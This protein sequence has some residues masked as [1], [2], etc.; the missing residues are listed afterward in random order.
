MKKRFL[1]I[2]GLCLLVFAVF[3]L[4]S[5]NNQSDKEWNMIVDSGDETDVVMA[6][7]TSNEAFL[8]YLEGD[9]SDYMREK[10]Q[11]R[12]VVKKVLIEQVVSKLDEEKAL[13]EEGQDV[14]GSYDVLLFDG[15]GY[16]EMR[17]K[18]LI[19]GPFSNNLE[20]LGLI[21]LY[22]SSFQYRD[23]VPNEGFFVPIARKMLTLLYSEDIFYESPVSYAELISEL[24]KLQ[25]M[26][27]YPDPRYSE[28]G[29]AFLLGM[30]Q[31]KVLMEPYVEPGRDL[32][33]FEQE[34]RAALRPLVKH[35]IGLRDAG[36][37]YPE[38]TEQLFTDGKTYF[39]M[40]LDF[41]RISEKIK[42]YEYPSSSNTF[43][44]KPVGSSTM[45]GVLPFDSVN[46]TG[47]MVAL[48]ELLSP[49]SQSGLY[50]SGLVSVY[51]SGTPEENM[52][53]LN[54][55]KLHRSILKPQKY[56]ES[57]G[58]DFDKEL[59]DIVVAVWE[60]MV[61]PKESTETGS[62]STNEQETTTDTDSTNE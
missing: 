19:Y 5:C 47:A 9:F 59:R 2:V 54:A 55:A 31:E 43:L 46:K 4:T 18:E 39:S 36:T 37:K 6:V 3:G 22:S 27:T 61:L 56:I 44:L 11:Q 51:Y 33:A 15:E 30:I 7:A 13:F 17:E 45:I 48:S 26:A 38:N 23:T 14:R 1:Q 8:S 42:N 35:R 24:G 10:H 50:L 49:R 57:A 25:G 21:D 58:V 62:G 52:Q 28:E 32:E 16:A 29:L 20:N 40:S 12:I 60:D 53:Q 34:V 41:L